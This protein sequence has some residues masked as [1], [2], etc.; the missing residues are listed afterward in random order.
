MP[1]F[2]H[3]YVVSFQILSLL[4]PNGTTSEVHGQYNN[5]LSAIQGHNSGGIN[6]ALPADSNWDT[7]R[8]VQIGSCVVTDNIICF[9][10]SRPYTNY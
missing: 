8:R 7:N 1:R 4:C 5:Y 6:E 9:K 3:A 10:L 2:K